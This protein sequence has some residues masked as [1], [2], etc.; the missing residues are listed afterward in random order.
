MAGIGLDAS[1]AA[2]TNA[3]VRKRFGWVA[4]SD[5]I[6]RSVIGNRQIPIRYTLDDG[7]ARSMRAHTIIV[8]NCGTLTASVLLLPRAELSG[9]TT[10]MLAPS[11]ACYRA[12]SRSGRRSRCPP[13]RLSP[14]AAH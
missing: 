1:M 13:R 11:A 14:V 8:G 10:E 9:T 12:A 5:P 2:D 7:P 6:A 4:Y 3:W